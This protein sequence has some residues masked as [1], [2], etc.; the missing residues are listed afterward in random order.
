MEALRHR[1]DQQHPRLAAEAPVHR[2]HALAQPRPQEAHGVPVL[3]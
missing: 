3:G 1:V 2:L